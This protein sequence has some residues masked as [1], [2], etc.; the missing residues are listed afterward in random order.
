[1][2][3]S[4]YWQAI[5][6]VPFIFAG[7]YFSYMYTLEVKTEF[8]YRRTGLISV[9]TLLS[10]IINICLNLIFIPKFGYIAAAITTTISYLFLFVFHY[11][12][13]SKVI[14]RKVYGLKFHLTSFT[15]MVIIIL[16]YVFF[17]NVL[18]IRIVGIFLSIGILALNIKERFRIKLKMKRMK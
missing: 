10:A 18:F 11:M 3:D 13:T 12:I 8:F 14:K 1:M 4:S 6:I 5:N 17:K 15:Y 9:G 7:Y 2:A 16:Y